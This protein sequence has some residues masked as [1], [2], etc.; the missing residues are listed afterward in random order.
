MYR[1][2]EL[3]NLFGELATPNS[4]DAVMTFRNLHNWLGANMDL[5]FA[6][7]KGIKAGRN[8]WCS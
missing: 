6:T 8:L 4:V 7:V 2:V 1:N 5:I 3:V